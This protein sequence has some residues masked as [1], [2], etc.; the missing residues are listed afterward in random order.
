MLFTIILFGSLN[1]ILKIWLLIFPP[2]QP[3][4]E[5][6]DLTII[7]F[8]KNLQIKEQ[9]RFAWKL[10]IRI[11]FSF[12]I[13]IIKNNAEIIY[14]TNLELFLKSNDFGQII[15]ISFLKFFTW[16]LEHV[17]IDILL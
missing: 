9:Y 15:E 13:K 7:F 17:I 4:D 12:K 11:F 10:N 14:L 5:E 2:P 6:F 3:D 1:K 16:S 8:P